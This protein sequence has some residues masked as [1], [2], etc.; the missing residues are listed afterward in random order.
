M[1]LAQKQI[2]SCTANQHKQEP[3]IKIL[4][5][6]FSDQWGVIPV[7]AVM[8]RKGAGWEVIECDAC[9]HDGGDLSSEIMAGIEEKARDIAHDREIE[10]AERARDDRDERADSAAYDRHIST[11]Q[12]SAFVDQRAENTQIQLNLK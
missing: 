3:T 6:Y 10:A 8:E 5:S 11:S 12:E 9:D 4:F 2:P 7:T 1:A